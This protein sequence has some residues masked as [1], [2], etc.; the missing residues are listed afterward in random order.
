MQS[1]TYVVDGT[2]GECFV[3]VSFVTASARRRRHPD[4]DMPPFFGPPAPWPSDRGRRLRHRRKASRGEGRVGN[5]AVGQLRPGQV[6]QAR[7][8]APGMRIDAAAI[9]VEGSDRDIT[10]RGRSSIPKELQASAANGPATEYRTGTDVL[11][12]APMFVRCD[13]G[14]SSATS[15]RAKSPARRPWRSSTSTTRANSPRAAAT[16]LFVD[17]DGWMCSSPTAGRSAELGRRPCASADRGIRVEA[18]M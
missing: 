14:P 15:L 7:R 1:F 2:T 16:P 3:N 18:P 12:Q 10:T 6:C 8:F 4:V 11:V 5:G 13:G 17:F 9:Q